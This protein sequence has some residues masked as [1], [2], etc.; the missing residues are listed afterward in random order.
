[1]FKFVFLFVLCSLS[2]CLVSC[3]G[4]MCVLVVCV[5]CLYVCWLLWLCVYVQVVLSLGLGLIGVYFSF[6][7]TNKRDKQASENDG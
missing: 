6:L 2:V 1:M 3:V 4:C 5:C 7:E